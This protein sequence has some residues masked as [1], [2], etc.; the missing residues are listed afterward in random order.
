MTGENINQTASS[1]PSAVTWPDSVPFPELENNTGYGRN[2]RGLVDALETIKIPTDAPVS[3]IEIGTEL[4]GSTRNFLRKFPNA[5]IVSIDPYIGNYPL[6]DAWKEKL[7]PLAAKDGG[8]LLKIFQSLFWE[9]RDRIT[10]IRE[11]SLNGLSALSKAGASADIVFID[12]DH[13]YH[14]ALADLMLSRC[15]FPNAVLLGDDMGFAPNAPK[16]KGYAL[17]VTK[18]VEDFCDHFETTYDLFSR[19]T[20]LI[21]PSAYAPKTW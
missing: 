5:R 17:P 1:I 20:F 13:R 2:I 11:F 14:G 12:G 15:L 3:I 18:A 8:S 10:T 21:R 6:P 19:N 4:G 7:T 9:Y 16:Y